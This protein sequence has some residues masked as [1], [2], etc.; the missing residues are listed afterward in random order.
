MKVMTCRLASV[1]DLSHGITHININNMS[2]CID[3]T[4]QHQ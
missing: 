3:Y 1:N 2:M 4:C